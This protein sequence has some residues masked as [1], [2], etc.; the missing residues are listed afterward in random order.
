[1]DAIDLL[2][3]GTVHGQ[4]A[5][6]IEGGSGADQVGLAFNLAGPSTPDRARRYPNT[7]T[8]P[9]TTNPLRTPFTTPPLA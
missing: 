4:L 7:I 1:M 2:A 6:D 8:M 5:F 9:M 3:E